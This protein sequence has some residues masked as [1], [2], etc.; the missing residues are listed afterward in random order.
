MEELV[1]SCPKCARAQKQRAQPFMMSTFP[2]IPWQ[3]VATDLFEW[4]KENY[5][6]TVDYYSRF[7]EVAR[8]KPTIA[9]EAIQHMKSIFARYGFSEVVI[10][11]N[12]PQ[13]SGEAY[14]QFTQEY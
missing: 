1:K 12:G 4:K 7:I 8:L 14:K 6:L 5:L 9:E 3:K 11:E 13:Y 10:S 2:E